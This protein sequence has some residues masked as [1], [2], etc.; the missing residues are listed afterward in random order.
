MGKPWWK[1]LVDRWEIPWNG[2]LMVI[3]IGF[4]GIFMGFN[5]IL[6]GDLVGFNGI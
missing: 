3:F 5:G 1:T 4:N 6:N 2:D